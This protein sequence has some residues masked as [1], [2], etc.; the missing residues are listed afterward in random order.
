MSELLWLLSRRLLRC[1]FVEESRGDHGLLASTSEDFM[2]VKIDATNKR[3]CKAG[4]RK[5]FQ[6]LLLWGLR[7]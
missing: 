1:A 3:L 6:G 2:T 7:E 5:V 4:L